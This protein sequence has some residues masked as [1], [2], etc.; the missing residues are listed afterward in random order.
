MRPLA[1]GLAF[2]ALSPLAH[3]ADGDSIDSAIHALYDVISGPAG[4]RDWVR[5]HALFIDGGRLIPSRTTP[6]G[7]TVNVMTPD[8][9]AKRAG[10]GFE[11]QAFYESELSRKV[12][13]FGNVVH[14]FSTYESRRAP[15][16]K[17][18]A[19]GINSIQLVKEGISWKIV[20]VLWDSERD[21][22]PLP[23]KYL[24]PSK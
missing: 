3:A 16:E 15:G 6:Q 20:T 14:A 12:E 1:L 23:E 19:R 9:Y 4:G 2:L 22:N 10:A 5:F 13:T 11:K 17:P 8:D 7:P 24:S 18:F 21:G